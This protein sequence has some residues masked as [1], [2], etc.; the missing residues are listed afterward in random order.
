M[1]EGA[2]LANTPYILRH[3]APAAVMAKKGRGRPRKRVK[4]NGNGQFQR[5]EPTAVATPDDAPEPL[6]DSTF[7]PMEEDEEPPDHHDEDWDD[8]DT[9]AAS[10]GRQATL[11]FGAA[12]TFVS[13][14]AARTA[15]AVCPEIAPPRRAAQPLPCRQTL[16]RRQQASRAAALPG[17]AQFMSSWLGSGA[18]QQPSL[19]QS[20]E[21]EGA[22]ETEVGEE[23]SPVPDAAR[24]AEPR[25]GDD[26]D[27][28]SDSDSCSDSDMLVYDGMDLPLQGWVGE[29][30]QEAAQGLLENHCDGYSSCGSFGF[31]DGHDYPSDLSDGSLHSSE[32]S[33]ADAELDRDAEPRRTGR[34]DMMGAGCGEGDAEIDGDA[35][36]RG[37]GGAAATGECG[38]SGATSAAAKQPDAPIRR[39]SRQTIRGEYAPARR[40]SAKRI[41]RGSAG[42]Y[43]RLLLPDEVGNPLVGLRRKKD[44]RLRVDRKVKVQQRGKA[45]TREQLLAKRRT[46]KNCS[47]RK[48]E[49]IAIFEKALDKIQK[50][51]RVYLCVCCIFRRRG[52]RCVA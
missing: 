35:N 52:Y 4:R 23:E 10:G 41:E 30:Q 37:G 13:A 17:M 50:V 39:S 40:A 24:S 18:G 45:W 43:S 31:L 34:A 48:T 1:C 36:H 29:D 51:C 12:A 15:Q 3:S 14:A 22:V 32:E 2:T 16:H 33:D 20:S 21:T 25:S 44:K 38:S 6:D 26:G 5:R 11:S 28:E 49:L 8:E 19:P 27:G 7:S 47:K 9:A 42:R 46:R